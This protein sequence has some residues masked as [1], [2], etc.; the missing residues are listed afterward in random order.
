MNVTDITG[1]AHRSGS[2]PRWLADF[3]EQTPGGVRPKQAEAHGA[4]LGH[5]R[6]ATYR[7]FRR[8]RRAAVARSVS[9]HTWPNTTTW[10]PAEADAEATR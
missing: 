10:L 9:R 8:L 4:R 3:I 6:N 7:A 5:N 2:D 1:R